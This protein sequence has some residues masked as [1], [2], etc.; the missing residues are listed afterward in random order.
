MKSKTMLRILCALMSG[1]ISAVSLAAMEAPS[2]VAAAA[3]KMPEDA[4]AHK[5]NRL[6]YMAARTRSQIRHEASCGQDKER[7][8]ELLDKA[9]STMRNIEK[10]E[11]LVSGWY[12]VYDTVCRLEAEEVVHRLPID[13]GEDDSLEQK[14]FK[15]G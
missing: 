4:S 12:A 10:N 13:A 11:S 14:K 1:C 8:Q 7:E 6:M 15:I 3:R 5:E 9:L 2:E